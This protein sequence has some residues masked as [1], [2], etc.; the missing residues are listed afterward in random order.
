M[1]EPSLYVKYKTGLPLTQKGIIM[2]TIQTIHKPEVFI[3]N[4]ENSNKYVIIMYDT[5]TMNGIK[6]QF[7]HWVLSTEKNG[8]GKQEKEKEILPYYKPTPPPGS[9]RHTYTFALYHHENENMPLFSERSISLEKALG[10]L[11]IQE[12]NPIASVSFFINANPSGGRREKTRKKRGK[13]KR[14][15]RSLN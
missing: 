1:S 6:S 10:L 11:G 15:L 14:T 4:G 12:R 5:F 8:K 7:I 3:G 9:G 13:K 2:N